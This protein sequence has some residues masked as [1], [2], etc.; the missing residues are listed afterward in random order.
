MAGPPPLELGMVDYS[1]QAR[2]TAFVD[3]NT[4]IHN[5]N[6]RHLEPHQRTQQTLE[7]LARDISR[8]LKRRAPQFFSVGVRLYHGWHKGWQPTDNLR[9]I[10]RLQASLPA[11]STARVVFR[12]PIEYGH[13][14][15]SAL[16][17]RRHQRPQIHL[18]NTLREQRDKDRLEEKL[19]DTALTADL[20]HWARTTP[21]EWA[22]VLSEDDDMVPPVLTA[23]SWIHSRG[24][25]VVIVRRRAGD[26]YY[27]LDR[28]L[29]LTA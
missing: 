10:L 9:A 18:P 6:A 28:L 19:V 16:P 27:R 7:R 26:A 24:G 25:K 29:E 22:L 5:A 11:L 2:A 12:A 4:Q 1:P 8:V 23:E 20:L 13:T 15:L 3:W 14:L 17:G 21:D